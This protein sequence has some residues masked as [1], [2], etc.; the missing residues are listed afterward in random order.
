M[1]HFKALAA[2]ISAV[3]LAAMS[4]QGFPVADAADENAT[5]KA[6]PVYAMTY[7]VSDLPIYSQD[8]ELDGSILIAY[9][10]AAVDSKTWDEGSQIAP[11]AR[12]GRLIIVTTSDNHKTIGKSLEAFRIDRNSQ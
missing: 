1:R 2:V 7:K 11:H 6:E 4:T 9:V 10:K 8:G 5:P 12:N 3:V